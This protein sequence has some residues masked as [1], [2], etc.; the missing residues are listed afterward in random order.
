M[1]KPLAPKP[2]RKETVTYH[3]AA[4][5][6][7]SYLLR[8]YVK[9]GDVT[10]E[11]ECRLS[12]QPLKIDIMIIKKNREVEI[13]TSWGRIFREYNVVE[14][15]SPADS[16]PTLQVFN[17]VVHGYVGIYAAQKNIKLTNMTAS[18]VCFK[19][20][21]KLFEMLEKEFG[22]RV[23]RKDDGIY[24]IIQEGVA[25][26][27]SL[28]VQIIV[29]SELQDSELVLKALRAKM[30]EAIE[31]KV[32][33]EVPYTDDEDELVSLAYWWH[34]IIMLNPKILKKMEEINMIKADKLRKYMIE[35]GFL[36]EELE[37]AEQ[38]GKQIG[39]RRGEQKGEQRGKL[40]GMQQVFALLEEGYTPAQAKKKLQLA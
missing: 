26:E 8:E 32:A 3:D 9:N 25:A 14:Y 37:K 16:L 35:N 40:Q 4:F 17:K 21:T 29:S 6:A 11:D 34:A 22:Y 36:T 5:A 1:S 33:V 20:P 31:E 7:F 30:D 2:K 15:K 10:L 38:R 12:K 24:Y 19:K 28:A 27:K 23:L 13:K 18:I 39:E